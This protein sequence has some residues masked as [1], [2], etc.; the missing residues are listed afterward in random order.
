MESCAPYQSVHW[1][2]PEM[3]VSSDISEDLAF[4]PARV[5]RDVTFLGKASRK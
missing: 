1:K 3:N 4:K 2:W 5:N